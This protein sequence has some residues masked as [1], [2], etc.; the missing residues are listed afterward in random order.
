[1]TDQEIIKF[2]LEW[3]IYQLCNYWNWYWTK[4]QNYWMKKVLKEDLLDIYVIKMIVQPQIY[5]IVIIGTRVG[6]IVS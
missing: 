5:I 3:K 6:F 1:M 4:R 2:N